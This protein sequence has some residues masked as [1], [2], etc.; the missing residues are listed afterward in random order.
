MDKEAVVYIH[1]GV[2]LNHKRNTFESVLVKWM[3]LELVMQSEE[4]QKGKNKYRMLMAYIWNVA[5]WY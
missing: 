3:N 2:L 1:N 4:S 5:R